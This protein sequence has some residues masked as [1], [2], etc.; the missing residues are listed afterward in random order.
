MGYHNVFKTWRLLRR[1]RVVCLTAKDAAVTF[2][3]GMVMPSWF[4]IRSTDL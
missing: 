4:D 2:N 3:F 1:A